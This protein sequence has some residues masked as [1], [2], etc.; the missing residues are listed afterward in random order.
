MTEYS[1][2]LIKYSY[3]DSLSDFDGWIVITEEAEPEMCID[4]CEDIVGII[5]EAD[6]RNMLESIESEK[7]EEEDE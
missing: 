5:S 1:V 4:A 6:L 2:A 7:E 3:D